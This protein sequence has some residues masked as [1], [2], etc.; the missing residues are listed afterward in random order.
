M[1]TTLV[2]GCFFVQ[3]SLQLATNGPSNVQIVPPSKATRPR[4]RKDSEVRHISHRK[5]HQTQTCHMKLMLWGKKNTIIGD[6]VSSFYSSSSIT[7]LSCCFSPLSL[8][9]VQTK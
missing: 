2:L 3:T 5:N 1:R 9:I 4:Q 6:L 8:F 7:F